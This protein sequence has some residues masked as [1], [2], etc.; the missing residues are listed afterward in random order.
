MEE[1]AYITRVGRDVGVLRSCLYALLSLSLATL[2]PSKPHGE[3]VGSPVI[4]TAPIPSRNNGGL[5]LH[6]PPCTYTDV[7]KNNSAHYNFFYCGGEI[8]KVLRCDRGAINYAHDL[9]WSAGILSFV[10]SDAWMRIL[11]LI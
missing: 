6:P 3:I 1:V 9:W 11:V 2:Q 7:S 4:S 8:T 10:Q 5:R